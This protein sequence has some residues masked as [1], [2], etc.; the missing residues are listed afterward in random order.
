MMIAAHTPLLF[1]LFVAL[2]LCVYACSFACSFSLSCERTLHLFVCSWCVLVLVERERERERE[3]GKHT[4][5]HTHT[6]RKRQRET[7]RERTGEAK[8]ERRRKRER[9]SKKALE[10]INGGYC[11]RHPSVGVK[12]EKSRLLVIHA[13]PSKV[14]IWISALL[15]WNLLDYQLILYIRI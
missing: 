7:E 14:E 9:E 11:T 15:P 5:T 2:S 1:C 13:D 10:K 6:H 12:H 4:H 8:Q 3:R